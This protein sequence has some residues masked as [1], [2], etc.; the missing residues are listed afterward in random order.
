MERYYW[1]AKSYQIVEGSSNIQKLIIAR[2]AL[3]YRKANRKSEETRL[4][5]SS[6][7]ADRAAE[8]SGRRFRRIQPLPILAPKATLALLKST[9]RAEEV[10][11]TKGWPVDVREVKLAIGALPEQEAGKTDFAARADN[12]VR[13]R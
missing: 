2:D 4:T 1:D 8:N 3:G 10:D 7:V 5:F 9:Q 11:F 13:V 6:R 12:E